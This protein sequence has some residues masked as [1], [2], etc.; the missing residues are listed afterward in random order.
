MYGYST[1]MITY[2]LGLPL[3]VLQDLDGEGLFWAIKKGDHDKIKRSNVSNIKITTTCGESIE[4][5]DNGSD[6]LKE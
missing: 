1:K 4:L 5:S 2:V 6:F 3:G